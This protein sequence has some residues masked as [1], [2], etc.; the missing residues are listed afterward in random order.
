MNK[1]TIYFPRKYIYQSASI[2]SQSSISI[3]SSAGA[4]KLMSSESGVKDFPPPRSFTWFYLSKHAIYTCIVEIRISPRG[5][6][7]GGLIRK[8]HFLGWGLFEGGGLFED[9]RYSVITPQP[10]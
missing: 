7:L 10:G 1:N 3:V 2:S 9:L 5:L 4:A 6:I 8:N